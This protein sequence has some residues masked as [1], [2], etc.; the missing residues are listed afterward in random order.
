MCNSITT[1]AMAIKTSTIHQIKKE[2]ELLPRELLI[3]HCLR[4]A[5]YKKENKELLHY[6]LFESIDEENYVTEVKAE[7]KDGFKEINTAKFIYVKKGIRK[8]LKI[9]TKFIKHSGKK[10][11]EIELL[12][13]FCKE[14]Q[15]LNIPLRRST[16][17]KNLYE[18][19]LI[20][21]EKALT[22][23]HED[24]RIDYEDDIETIKKGL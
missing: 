11:T 8:I 18:R 10:E 19:Q 12:I 24:I 20:N 22:K 3:D 6:L 15:N 14:M 4:I 9:T 7:I 1:D 2:L 23:L 17:M 16:V 5:K 13:F 21:I